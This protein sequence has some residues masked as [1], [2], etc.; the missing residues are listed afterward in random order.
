MSDY[1]EKMLEL[2]A[3]EKNSDQYL[4]HIRFFY[5]QDTN[6]LIS[7]KIDEYTAENLKSVVRLEERQKYRLSFTGSRDIAR[8]QYTGI[9][10]RTC[11]EQS[12]PI[13][14]SCSEDY[15]RKLA[16]LKNCRHIGD[17]AELDFAYAGSGPTEGQAAEREAVEKQITKVQT[18]EKQIVYIPGYRKGTGFSV[19]VNA[20][21]IFSL[22]SLC[23]A[24]ISKAA[25]DPQAYA[26]AGPSNG[27]DTRLKDYA[28][29]LD[30]ALPSDPTDAP[31][32]EKKEDPP[33]KNSQ[34]DA[35]SDQDIGSNSDVNRK[36]DTEKDTGTPEN[37]LPDSSGQGNPETEKDSDA[38]DIADTVKY[39]DVKEDSGKKDA[40][41]TGDVPALPCIELDEA[42]TYGLP[43]GSV[44]LTFD[45][46]PSPYSAGIV[47]V[48]KEYEV[49][50]TFFFIGYNVARY[51]DA[52]KY[53]H[54]NGYSIGSH[55]MDHAKMT[56]LSCE[57]Q[58]YE[59]VQS[60]RSIEDIIKERVFLFRA[61]FGSFDEQ[62]ENLAREYQYK[63][64]LWNN[65][66]KDWKTRNADQ[67]FLHIHDTELSGSIIL[68]HESQAV[69]DTLPRVI[70]YIQKQ[71]LEM[72]SL[73]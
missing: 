52:V 28:L 51:P 69:V 22:V 39:S 17:L 62:V 31:E 24:F 6:V 18:A 54:Q 30:P 42:V 49:G 32:T 57:K 48:L 5:E 33:E 55:S 37:Q 63:L 46:G 15:I 64:V 4:L 44:A 23:C 43:E 66:P 2:L 47:D 27:E 13:L 3:L 36:P 58:E 73:R 14:F 34:A 16:A 35:K 67:I 9:V 10:T 53:V 71:D 11:C 61:P 59:M 70:E 25:S 8:K 72:V 29:P 60:I 65:D 41:D 26:Q 38:D 1:T 45:D 19:V 68:L 56:D 12:N 50:G 20:L 7:M 21:I 40:S